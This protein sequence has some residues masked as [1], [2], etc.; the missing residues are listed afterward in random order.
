MGCNNEEYKQVAEEDV[1]VLKIDEK[2]LEQFLIQMFKGGIDKYQN[3]RSK[4]PT[5]G[6][7]KYLILDIL[8]RFSQRV[9]VFENLKLLNGTDYK[10]TKNRQKYTISDKND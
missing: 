10:L 6:I 7:T 9:G 3:P 5:S 8:Y 4:Q 2:Q 1:S